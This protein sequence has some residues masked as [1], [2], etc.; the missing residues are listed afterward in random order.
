MADKYI[1]RDALTGRMKEKIGADVSTGVPDAGRVVALDASGKLDASLLPAG[2][3]SNSITL[4]AFVA[5]NQGELIEI[6]D[7]G[8]TA[9][10]RL[11]S[12]DFA[13]PGAASTSRA[14]AGLCHAED[15]ERASTL[16]YSCLGGYSCRPFAVLA[17]LA[18][19]RLV[20]LPDLPAQDG[21][22]R[23]C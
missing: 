14:C 9:K 19:G 1:E 17:A 10:A 7:D 18:D 4:E 5:I 16:A 8:G 21:C 13:A 6:F 11:A 22:L 2:V 12:A 3:S 20:R 23:A 15:Q